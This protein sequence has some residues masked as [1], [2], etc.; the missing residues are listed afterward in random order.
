MS[1]NVDEVSSPPFSSDL[2]KSQASVVIKH[3][4]FTY[5]H[6]TLLSAT[7]PASSAAIDILAARSYLT[8]ALQNY[9]GMTGTAIPVDFLK[10]EG[11]HIWIRLPKE[12]GPAFSGAISQWMG[13]DGT[14]SWKVESKGDWLGAVVAGDGTELFAP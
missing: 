3:P 8:S 7:I 6:L 9:L 1:S 12:D 14:L 13:K 4:I 10:V 11:R 2:P 5:F